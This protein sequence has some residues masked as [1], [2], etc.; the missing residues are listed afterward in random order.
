MGDRHLLRTPLFLTKPLGSENARSSYFSVCKVCDFF[1]TGWL[2]R[3][4]EHRQSRTS[5][6]DFQAVLSPAQQPQRHFHIPAR[7]R[8][9]QHR[10]DP[11][12]PQPYSI[13]LSNSLDS[14][15][16]A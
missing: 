5:E 16:G 15:V 10:H 9:L 7:S 12:V 11:S 8:K 14:K 6:R 2:L 3:R 13:C 1:A 4:G